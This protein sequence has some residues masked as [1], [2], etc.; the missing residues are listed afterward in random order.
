MKKNVFLL[1]A[2]LSFSLS[3]ATFLP[4][5]PASVYAQS[6]NAHVKG[7]VV[8]NSGEP[9]VGATV[10]VKGEKNTK[11]T[12]TD[13]DGNFNID[14]PVGTQLEVSF[15]GYAKQTVKAYNGMK[16][17]LEDD[18]QVLDDVVV[19]GYGYM[20]KSDLTG[21]VSQVKAA[22]LMK[23]SPTSLEQGLQ[24]RISGVNVTTND[25]APGGGISIQVRG[26]N[27]FNGSTEPLYV[28]DGVPVG[29]SNSDTFN[30][31]DSQ[32]NYTN[33]LSSLN[34]NDIASIEILKDASSTAIYG[35]R[36]ANGVV[37]ITTKSG[38]SLNVKDQV[39][40]SYKTTVANPVKKIKVLGAHD[41]AEYRNLSYI[42]TQEVSGYEWT[43]EN[44][45]FP[46]MEVSGV[47][48][49]GPNDYDNDPYYWQNQIFRTG[50]SQDLNLNISGQSKGMDYTI[51]GGYLNQEGVVKNSDYERYT[52]RLNLNRQVFNWLKVGS[53]V[54]GTFSK[55]N[56]LKTA[57]SNQN[58]GTEGIIRSAITFPATYSVDELDDEYSMVAQP[59]KYFTNLNENRSTMIRTS[60]YMN[61]SLAKGLIYR[62][63]IGFNSTH[64][65]ANKYW[66]SD[67]AEGKA[68]QGR[69]YAGDNWRTSF[70]FDNLLM[71]NRTFDKKHNVS[72][73]LG[74]S[75]EKSSFYSKQVAVQGFGTDATDGWQ[76]QDAAN[77]YSATS[78]KWD[79]Q[80]FSAIA[81]LSY[82]YANKYYIT[83]TAREDISSKFAKGKRDSFF[84]SV[85]LSYRLSE[86][87]FMKGIEN[88][89]SNVKIRYSYGASGN[90]AIGSYQT[91]ALMS[92]SNYPFGGNIV[93][94][95]ST[96][97]YNPGNENLTWE[98]TWQHDAGLELELF[99]R[100]NVELDY[101]NKKTTD[102]LQYR[103]TPPS[104]GI[105]QIMSNL[106]TVYN[107]GFEASV[108]A[109]VVNTKDWYFNIGA[110]ISFNKNKIQ[111]VSDDP[112]FPNTIY[113]SLRPYA[114]A[115]G[116]SIG[117]FYGYV[118]DGI[119]KD[120]DEVINSEQFKTKYPDYGTGDKNP[121]TEEII[122]R[123]WIGEYRYV[124][125]NGDGSITDEDQD[126][127]GD[128]NPEFFYGFNF[129]FGWKNLDVSLLFQGV[130]GNDIFNMNAL[131]YNNLGTTQNIPQYIYDRS[132]TVDPENGTNQKI[133]Y[134]SG[135]DLRFSRAYLED[136]SYLK[137]RTVSIGYSFR[138]PCKYIQNIRLNVVGNNLITWTKYHGYDPEVNSFGSTPTLR[139]IDSGAYPQARSFTFGLDV[140][141]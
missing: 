119:W 131:R 108:K 52:I 113:N 124:D 123:D 14:V 140:T 25:G 77:M 86:E 74:T 101:Y 129:D 133:F 85:G 4:L 46:G 43:Q 24:G 13:I 105:L 1:M 88:V 126:W 135:R 84:P 136:G 48:K 68:V 56:I 94:G 76:I 81:R 23:N 92:A 58:N 106:G 107:E 12:I 100:I 27:S 116:H 121:V 35:S 17:T 33:A 19:V 111:E 65:D 18:S 10:I 6:T 29:D 82:N 72:A 71:Y 96:N 90:Q 3:S 99:K 61:I 122:N 30:F 104:T 47:Y 69:S 20:K 60:N 36:G 50:V 5:A 15:I 83:F 57:T 8:D 49:K 62:T 134:Y 75:W 39:Q 70:L 127:I 128:A 9:I 26:T 53:T 32:K 114:I 80:L 138:K 2:G 117:S 89:V 21:S 42:N 110:N 22:D 93:N 98:T 34:P 112:M 125:K 118:L 97:T 95:Y 40:F 79:S 67:L 11:G 73:T 130:Q 103:Q 31:D 141:F 41:Y 28:I 37:L 55:S 54:S 66:P 78:S 109:N 115:N 102:L 64:N 16:I 38:E 137:L 132:V 139:G 63:V 59:S 7:T 87:K 120:R 91:F 44:L 45:P 51:S